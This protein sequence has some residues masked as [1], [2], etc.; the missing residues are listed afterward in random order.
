MNTQDIQDTGRQLREIAAAIE[1][2]RVDSGITKAALLR[3]YPELGTD[4]TFNKITRGEL[5]ELD[6]EG[7]W[8]PAYQHVWT[9]LN[10]GGGNGAGDDELIDD[11][12]G[13]VELCRAYLETRETRNNAR[14]ILVVGDSGIGKTSAV[15]VMK[16][17]PY[18]ANIIAVEAND[19][20]RSSKGTVGPF[21]REIGKEMGVK[22]LPVIKDQMFAE[23]CRLL[24]GR[25]RCL[26]VEEAHHLDPQGINILKSL[27]NQTPVMIIATAMP[28]LW[29]KL[30]SSREAYQECKQLTGNRLAERIHLELSTDDV[31]RFLMRRLAGLASEALIEKVAPALKQEAVLLGNLRFVEA[32]ARRFRREVKNGESADSETFRNVITL[33]KKRRGGAR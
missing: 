25:R 29:D 32:A 8:L 2:Y 13:P 1:T 27:I 14:F 10:E 15:N 3:S 11:L 20:W 17:K 28:V 18:G 21:L 16:G 30:A 7:R 26:I 6:V 5:D 19:A 4:K 31:R 12:S 24:Q 9:T 22:K 33:E 23:I